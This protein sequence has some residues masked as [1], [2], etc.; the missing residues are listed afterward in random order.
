MIAHDSGG[1][2]A[3]I[4]PDGAGVGFRAR[5]VDTYAAAVVR[6]LDTM[7]VEQRDSIRRAARE[8]ACTL[9]SDAVFDAQ[10]RRH[11]PLI[12]DGAQS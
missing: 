3:D 11:L 9:F 12:F 5:N 1:P 6:I 4:L 10:L 2:R 8:R 7:T